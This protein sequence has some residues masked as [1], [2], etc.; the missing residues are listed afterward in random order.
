VEGADR[1]IGKGLSLE[2]IPV[3][4]DGVHRLDGRPEAGPKRGD[5]CGV[6]APPAA[7]QP[8]FGRRR[9]MSGRSCDPCGRHLGQSGGPVGQRKSLGAEPVK[10]VAVE[11]FWRPPCKIGIG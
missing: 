5:Q 9:E 1:Q 11:R 7:D 3:P 4:A 6:A 2:R 10:I 8:F